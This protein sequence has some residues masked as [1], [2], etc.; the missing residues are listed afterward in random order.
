MDA[1]LQ[2]PVFSKSGDVWTLGRHR[3][4]CGDSTKAETY[5]TLMDDVKANL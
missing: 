2:K 1:E 3:L 4:V 5:T